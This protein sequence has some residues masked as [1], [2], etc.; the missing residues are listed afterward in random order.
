MTDPE[1]LQE[2]LR[3]MPDTCDICKVVI[4]TGGRDAGDKLVC[5]ECYKALEKEGKMNPFED[6]PFCGLAVE[7]SPISSSG[8]I[9]CPN[10]GVSM[11]KRE[12]ESLE[13]L[14]KRWNNRVLGIDLVANLHKEILSYLHRGGKQV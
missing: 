1:K 8:R 5:D 11:Y 14:T 9:Y 2:Y 7:Y 13:S 3:D 4:F 6:C 12:G 10:C